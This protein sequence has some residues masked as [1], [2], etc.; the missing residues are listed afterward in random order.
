MSSH[1][2]VLWSLLTISG[3]V[4][5]AEAQEAPAIGAIMQPPCGPMLES[6]QYVIPP[7]GGPSATG[8][9]Q[10][11]PWIKPQIVG[12][13]GDSTITPQLYPSVDVASNVTGFLPKDGEFVPISPAPA[14]PVA[15]ASPLDALPDLTQ[16]N[17]LAFNDEFRDEVQKLAAQKAADSVRN[18]LNVVVPE[19]PTKV[20][21]IVPGLNEPLPVTMAPSPELTP[22]VAPIIAE[23]CVD[24]VSG[25]V[26]PCPPT[27]PAAPAEPTAASVPVAAAPAAAAPVAPA[28]VAANPAA[29]S[30]VTATPVAATPVA[31]TP[32][33]FLGRESSA[34]NSA[35]ASVSLLDKAHGHASHRALRGL[36]RNM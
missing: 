35:T 30:P 36:K 17:V 31:A 29:A 10:G 9:I 12:E 7:C 14:T 22:G 33:Q 21:P 19:F 3:L 26:G 16:A 6:P 18:V 5:T 34:Q 28:P 2:G 24:C 15:E 8:T 27:N 13:I 20:V 4:A 23:P 11:G 32:V 25:A 1:R